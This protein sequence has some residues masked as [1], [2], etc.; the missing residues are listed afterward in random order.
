VER[1][2]LEPGETPPPIPILWWQY[3]TEVQGVDVG[4]SEYNRG[5]ISLMEGATSGYLRG[6][7][8]LTKN[9]RWAVYAVLY[10]VSGGDKNDEVKVV[11]NGNAGTAMHNDV[12]K[13]FPCSGSKCLSKTGTYIA[14]ASFEDAK[15]SYEFTW[16]SSSTSR[17]KH[18]WLGA[19]EAAFTGVMSESPPMPA[20]GNKK[21]DIKAMNCIDGKKLKLNQKSSDG[22]NVR[23]YTFASNPRLT[24]LLG[25]AV[26]WEGEFNNAKLKVQVPKP[27]TTPD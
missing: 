23:G 17:D 27:L 25:D 11:F 2:P 16:T 21:T 5:Q 3:R 18:M 14:D 12:K 4:V 20:G 7:M 9:G 24:V 10:A 6:E 22:P 19:G 1:P 15:V 8:P 26:I 13:G